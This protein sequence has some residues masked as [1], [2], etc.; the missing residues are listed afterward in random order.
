[1]PLPKA[2]RQAIIDVFRTRRAGAPALHERQQR[3]L[4]EMIRC[5][6]ADSPFYHALYAGLPEGVTDL[7]VL[8]PITKQQVMDRFDDLFTDRGINR[9]AVNDF[10]ADPGNIGRPFLGQYLVC[11]TSGTTGHPGVFISDEFTR[12]IGGALTRIRGGL[13]NWYGILGALQFLLRGR[14]YA[15]LDVSGGP[16]AGQ[17]SIEWYLR[18]HPKARK[19]TRL[20]SVL[21]SLATQVAE[22]NEF[23]PAAIGGYPSSIL[24]LARE[25]DA[26]RLHI[27]P[28]FIIFVG[29]T[30]TAH[31][32]R[33][34]EAAF[35]CASYEEYGSTENNV[36]AVQCKQGWLHYSSDWFILEPVD[37][38]YRPVAP[39]IR[40]DTVLI[41]NLVN[42]LMPLIR[43]DQG[44]SITLKPEPCACGSAFPAMRVTGRKDDLLDLRARNGRGSVAVAPLNLVTVIEETPGVYRIQVI[45]KAP[46]TLEIRLQVTRDAEIGSVWEQLHRRVHCYLDEQGIGAVEIRLSTEAPM[47]N[48]RSGKYQQV[49]KLAT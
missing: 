20:I 41:T 26:G 2:T 44:D 43:Y 3:R 18:E 29:E 12:S 17:S 39:G 37:K 38:D 32:R 23:Q 33:Y 19:T 45:Q 6:R 27:R 13:T 47:Q 14:R 11:T 21:N 5:A 10:I 7:S 4:A 48:P 46:A 22:L 15:L 24:I 31:S 16:Y 8:P 1:M 36:M 9:R 35:G 49:I 28:Q 40:S 42:R 25:Q 30:V 34:I